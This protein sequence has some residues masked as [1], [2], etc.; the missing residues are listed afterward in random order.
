MKEGEFSSRIVQGD[1][2]VTN[3]GGMIHQPDIIVWKYLLV[4]VNNPKHEDFGRFW[5]HRS[6]EPVEALPHN[7]V[8]PFG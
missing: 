2:L 5:I 7:W 3:H 8:G 4:P 6:S 1:S